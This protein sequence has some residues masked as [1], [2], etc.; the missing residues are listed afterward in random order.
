MRVLCAPDKLRGG[1]SAR[2]AAEALAAGVV[3]AGYEAVA[4]PLADG[5]E[6]TLDVLG[7]RPSSH[8]VTGP[9]GTPLDVVRGE[10]GNPR[11]GLS[12]IRTVESARVVGHA[13]ASRGD[14]WEITTQG[15]G[16]LLGVQPYSGAE[17]DLALGGTASC[18]GGLGLLASF[19][20]TFHD[21]D[22]KRLAPIGRSLRR[23]WLVKH[24][25]RRPQLRGRALC[26]I[27]APLLGAL[28]FAVQKGATPKQCADARPGLQR[29]IKAFGD[30]PGAGAA[31]GLGLAAHVLG[32]KPVSGAC[33]I[34]DAL[35][36]NLDAYDLIF[37]AEGCLDQGT[38]AGKV[39]AELAS[40]APGRLVLFV[41]EARVELPGATVIVLR[42][43]PAH[44]VKALRNAAATFMRAHPR[45][46]AG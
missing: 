39:A 7:L 5:G 35:E 38:L 2:V 43:G 4:Q 24:P 13:V 1:C 46:R 11:R 33:A 44:A 18:D 23:L 25:P 27:S 19:G 26:D 31:G 9:Y 41:G 17:V 15:I 12:G 22:G 14:P 29:L 10:P 6:G 32:L 36:L 30:F 28:D 45:G 40:R 42:G 8:R 16:E 34:I 20:Y 21:Q 3:K 37:T